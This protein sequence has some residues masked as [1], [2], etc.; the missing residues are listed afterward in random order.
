MEF[1]KGASLKERDCKPEMSRNSGSAVSC[2][3]ALGLGTA[4]AV[5]AEVRRLNS[6]DTGIKKARLLRAGLFEYW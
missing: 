5:W 6:G 4:L 3:W 1:L 2:I